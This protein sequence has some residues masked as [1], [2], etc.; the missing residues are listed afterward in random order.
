MER[1]DEFSFALTRRAL[2]GYG[3]TPAEKLALQ[4]GAA[5]TVQRGWE[6][7]IFLSVKL[8]ALVEA[9]KPEERSVA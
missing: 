7:T 5:A 9:G 8:L 6:S 2:V 4:Q 3:P 1:L